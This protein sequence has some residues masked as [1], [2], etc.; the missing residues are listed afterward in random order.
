MLLLHEMALAAGSPDLQLALDLERGLPMTR[1][2]PFSGNRDRV[3]HA[4]PASVTELRARAS[5]ANA[6]ILRRMKRRG[7]PAGPAEGRS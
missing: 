4:A 5:Q 1:E 3:V 6:D 7:T 2:L